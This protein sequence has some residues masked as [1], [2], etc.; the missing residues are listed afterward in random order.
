[1]MGVFARLVAAAGFKPVVGTVATVLRWVRFPST[2]V[3][4]SLVED[5]VSTLKVR[6]KVPLPTYFEPDRPMSYSPMI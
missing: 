4:R 1:M 6:R 3:Y 5:R 2:P